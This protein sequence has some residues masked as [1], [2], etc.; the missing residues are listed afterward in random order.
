MACY[1]N[2]VA[3]RSTLQ[4]DAQTCVTRET[5][6][7]CWGVTRETAQEYVWKTMIVALANQKGG[8]G[9]T[10]TSVNLG[11]ELAR[12]G[13]RVLLVD[14]DPQGN[15]TTSL[16]VSKRGLSSTIYNVL[17]D[18]V[19]VH[20]A[21]IST[22]RA[23]YDIIPA[24]ENLA[25]AVVELDRAEHW[26]WRL[27]DALADAPEYDWV[28]ID[29]PPSLG[30]LTISA[31][32]AAEQ[33]VI[34]LQCEY[35]ALEGLAQ[36]KG[37]ID[38][39]RDQLNPQLTLVGVL[40]TMYDGR[41]NLAQQVVEEVRKYFPRQIFDTL[42]PRSVRVGEAPSYGQLLY[43]YDPNNRAARAYAALAEEMLNRV[44]RS[45]A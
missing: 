18:N 26:E 12:R 24:T 31:L 38:R 29:S 10:T 1:N 27:R 45:V 36:I 42:I 25:G 6:C 37:T 14:Y 11:G 30:M 41:I 21:I 5:A 7:A 16:G 4:P 23:N 3:Q 2:S 22:E 33:V 9:K 34:P 15:A 13:Q 28:I 44:Q 19:P 43:E 8:V 20:D 40:M 17:V 39:V 32:C 35:L